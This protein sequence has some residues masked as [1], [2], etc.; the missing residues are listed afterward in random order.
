MFGKKKGIPIQLDKKRYLK[1][2]L[3]GMAA[4]EMTTRKPIFLIE[5]IKNLEP[6][7]IGI[8]L[9]ACLIHE[10]LTLDETRKIVDDLTPEQWDDVARKLPEAWKQGRL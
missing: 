2:E 10:G 9:W 1:L 6:G 7:E 3:L 4:F 5:T 8:L